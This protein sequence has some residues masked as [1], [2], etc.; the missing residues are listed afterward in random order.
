[1]AVLQ[2]HSKDTNVLQ[3]SSRPL[4]VQQESLPNNDCPSK[5][6]VTFVCPSV[7]LPTYDSFIILPVILFVLQCHSL[8]TTASPNRS[9]PLSVLQCPC[10]PSS[11]GSV[12]PDLRLSYSVPPNHRLSFSLLGKQTV[13][14][15]WPG[16]FHRAF[17]SLIFQGAHTII[18]LLH[19]PSIKQLILS[20]F[21]NPWKRTESSSALGENLYLPT[22]TRRGC[23]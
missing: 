8:S 14:L 7:S 2:C 15:F 1:M 18:S 6:F 10:R 9:P 13:S 4:L 22:P 21:Y 23:S 19:R 16:R 3:N 5:S 17:F 11:V 12:P 20:R